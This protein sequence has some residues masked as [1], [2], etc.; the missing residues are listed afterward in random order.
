MILF[1]KKILWSSVCLWHCNEVLRYSPLTKKVLDK[2]VNLLQKHAVCGTLL[3]YHFKI[4]N[5][6]EKTT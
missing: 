4:F 2:K 3:Q 5:F 1:C 6:Y